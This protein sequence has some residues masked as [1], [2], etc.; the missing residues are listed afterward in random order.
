[1]KYINRLFLNIS[2]EDSGKT[3]ENFEIEKCSFESCYLSSTFN[4]SLRTKVKN[5]HLLDCKQKNSIVNCAIIE[6]SIIENLRSKSILKF[7]GAVFNRVVFKGDIGSIMISPLLHTA[8]APAEVQKIFDREN[9][10]YYDNVQWAIDI[11]RANF[12]ECDIRGLSSRFI[13]RDEST[14]IVISR[15]KAEEIDWEDLD[16]ENEK[17]FA[18]RV[19]IME[20][21]NYDDVLI[22]APKLSQRYESILRD[23]NKLKRV[24]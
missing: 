3:I 14:Q 20:E 8:S 21:E 22:V 16:L 15:S 17:Y 7:W 19:N 6:D 5:I 2:D 23:L 10:I 13:I 4:P 24:L 18:V 12:E 1:M 9:K 11:S